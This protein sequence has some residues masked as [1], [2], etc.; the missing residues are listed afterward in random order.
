MIRTIRSRV[1]SRSLIS[2]ALL[3]VTLAFPSQ[4][5]VQA[6]EGDLDATF[7]TGGKLTIDVIPNDSGDEAAAVAALPD[8]RIIVAGTAISFGNPFRFAVLRLHSNG[9]ID[10]TFGVNGRALVGFPGSVDDRAH[11]LAIQS[12]GKIVV[13]GTTS[14]VGTQNFAVARLNGNGS[15]DTTFGSGGLVSADF[16]DAESAA[17]VALQS[18]GRIIVGGQ[19]SDGISLDF[20]LARFNTDGSLDTS[21]DGDGRVTTTF[22]DT[23]DSVDLVTSVGVQADGRIVAAGLS[24][25]STG[26][27]SGNAFALTRYTS[28]GALDPTFGVGGKVTTQF[29]AGDFV[30]IARALVIQPNGRILLA[31]SATRPTQVTDFTLARYETN[32]TLDPAFGAG[33]IVMTDIGVSTD[34]QAAAV[35]LQP[36]GRIVVAG[37]SGS[38]TGLDFAVARYEP[39]GNLDTSFGTGGTVT[40]DI[41]NSVDRATGM[42]IQP[43]GGILVVG[44][45]LQFPALR[46]DIAL[47]RYDGPPPHDLTFFPRG[48]DLPGTSGP[49][50]MRQDA[51]PQRIVL[52]S[53]PAGQSWLSEPVVNGAFLAG[54]TFVFQVPCVGF[55]LPKAIRVSTT[56][57]S[58]ANEQVLGETSLPFT[59]PCFISPLK[60]DVPV[61]TPSIVANRRLK[62]TVR[63]LTATPVPVVVGNGT[64]LRATNFVGVP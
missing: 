59:E 28:N 27:S 46:F 54:S 35:A 51:P 34:D 63:P 6:A 29:G 52:A 48:R 19:R 38:A 20:A 18:D 49:L 42:A 60:I 15:L 26:G 30:T 58:G 64:F 32:G 31:G 57:A 36:D 45:L 55:S 22:V 5:V 1:R 56:D 17:A 33:G 25:P 44:S 2:V 24:N 13:A 53:G 50:T 8:G 3:A 12:D 11:A 47:A 9:A 62:L 21:F 37:S 40:T 39:N 61:A 16:G 23:P 43:D 7:G 41:D 14:P 10:T 4:V